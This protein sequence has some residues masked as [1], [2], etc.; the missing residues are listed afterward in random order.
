MLVVIAGRRSCTSERVKTGIY[1]W[2]QTGSFLW[3]C[4]VMLNIPL[5]GSKEGTRK[6]PCCCQDRTHAK[7][8]Y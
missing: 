2:D 5:G 6:I 4:G 1:V 7:Q 8:P 3:F